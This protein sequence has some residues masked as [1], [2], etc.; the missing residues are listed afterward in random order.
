MPRLTE[1]EGKYEG[2][3]CYIV[4]RGASLLDVKKEHFGPGPVIVLNEAIQNVYR[5]KLGGENPI[6]SQ[7][8]NGDVLEN[9]PKYL[10]EGDA[11]I[12]CDD[13]VLDDPPSSSLF[14]DYE[15]R[16][17][18]NCKYDLGFEPAATFS[19]KAA[20]EI[21]TQI[22][23]CKHLVMVGFDS[24]KGDFQ[25]VL[26]EG[27]VHSEFRPGDYHEQIQIVIS[28]LARLKDV[29]ADWFFPNKPVKE[30][31]TVKLNIGCGSVY[32]NGYINIDLHDDTA[33]VKADA[34]KLPF[35][36]NSV[37]EIYSSHL[38][39]HFSHRETFDV[40][41]EWHRV[42]K[43]GGALKMNLPNLEWCVK[44]WLN[45]P[46]EKRWG[47][48]LRTIFGLQTNDGEY[49]KNGFS[50][51]HL[52]CYLRRTGFE[53]GKVIDHWSH[54]QQCFWVTANAKK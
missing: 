24:Y 21:A 53:N 15:S 31:E 51:P 27:F 37:D 45:Q 9:L 43:P 50:K 40:L 35:E 44:N 33:D 54:D 14:E 26:G 2:Q 12:L 23:G 17:V 13:P 16:Y 1:L 39:E 49:H 7:W 30:T 28:R 4:G 25:T 11:M 32:E 6:F 47:F 34:R 42:L 29:K 19:H 38:L 10:K 20:I 22:F 3:T 5:L 48:P 52:E 18:F 46:E 8:R 41:K 36:D